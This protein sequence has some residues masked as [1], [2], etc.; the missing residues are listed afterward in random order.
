MKG[1]KEN[2]DKDNIEIIIP[3]FGPIKFS[4]FPNDSINIKF[5]GHLVHILLVLILRSHIRK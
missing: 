5:C 3:C 1:N 4:S 2:G